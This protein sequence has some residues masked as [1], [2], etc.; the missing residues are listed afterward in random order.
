V[1][2]W[3]WKTIPA[4]NPHATDEWAFVGCCTN[5]YIEVAQW[6][7]CECAPIDIH[8]QHDAAFKQSCNNEYTELAQWLCSIESSYQVTI[9]DDEIIR[10]KII[11]HYLKQLDVLDDD[12]SS[13]L[14]N[15]NIKSVHKQPEDICMI[16]MEDHTNILQLPCNHYYCLES[17]LRYYECTQTKEV[18]FYCKKSYRFEDC[19]NCVNCVNL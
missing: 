17:L 7:W 1:A 18:C 15:L 9:E 14:N 19:V 10:W 2:Q 3:L 16:C 4:I 5:G 11:D 12:Y 13:A 6:L 8:A